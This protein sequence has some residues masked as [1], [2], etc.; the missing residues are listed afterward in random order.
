MRGAVHESTHIPIISIQIRF[1]GPYS[2]INVDCYFLL[3]R[4]AS[5][6]LFDVY[7]ISPSSLYMYIYIKLNTHICSKL[8]TI[9]KTKYI[10]LTPKK[11]QMNSA[12]SF[13][14]FF[15]VLPLVLADLQV[16]FYDS[17]CPQAESIVQQVV[18]IA[19][20]K[21]PSITAA[22]LRMHFHDCFVRVRYIYD[23]CTQNY[24]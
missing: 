12:V 10:L 15:F 9:D 23:I 16:G 17:T 22:F 6:T 13:L 8:K 24:I 19:F 18:Q 21:D 2:S 20:S 5:Y 3:A 11:N 14:I 1:H 4:H 7:H